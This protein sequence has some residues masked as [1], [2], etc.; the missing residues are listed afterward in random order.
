MFERGTEAA[1]VCRSL[2]SPGMSGLEARAMKLWITL[3]VYCEN[4]KTGFKSSIS[5]AF[6]DNTGLDG[7]GGFT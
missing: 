2:C 7:G 6:P 1:E 3:G 4:R 5:L